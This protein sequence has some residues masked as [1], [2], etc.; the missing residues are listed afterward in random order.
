MQ[1]TAYCCLG[2]RFIR[3]R[4]RDVTRRQGARLPDTKAHALPRNGISHKERL[5]EQGIK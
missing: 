1:V 4:W 2:K 5:G 3:A